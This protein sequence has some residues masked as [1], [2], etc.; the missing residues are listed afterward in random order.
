MIDKTGR[1]GAENMA[2]DEVLLEECLSSGQRFVRIYTWREPT[3]SLGYFQKSLDDVATLG[4]LPIVRRLSG[5]GAIL[6]HH[7]VTYSCVV[8]PGNEWQSDPTELYRVVHDVIIESLFQV[9]YECQLEYR[10][11][12]NPNN[13]E[14]LCF[15]RGDKNDLI[16]E[17]H[18]IVGSA[19]R[20]RRGAI[21]QH[22][23]I[24]LKRSHYTPVFSGLSDLSNREFDLKTLKT[25]LGR[26]IAESISEN[27]IS[28]SP[29]PE[30]LDRVN[31]KS[32]SYI[33]S[34]G[35]DL[36]C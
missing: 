1:S 13:S 24:L 14:F 23:S 5:G 10:K 35:D 3:L 22:G 26:T 28:D 19:Q 2:L 15:G 11:P 4:R 6:H 18:K 32:S 31:R 12:T 36:D 33:V 25:D 34:I 16:S 9:P 21:L 17:G 29:Q 8:P 7:E 20:R 27:T 30:I